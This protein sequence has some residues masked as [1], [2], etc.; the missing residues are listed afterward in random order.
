MTLMNENQ[1]PKEA[2][3]SMFAILLL[4]FERMMLMM[5][6]ILRKGSQRARLQVFSS[7]SKLTF[8]PSYRSIGFLIPLSVALDATPHV[9]DQLNTCDKDT[10]ES[11]PNA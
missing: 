2:R 10:N 3:E 4:Q 11:A 5:V 6:V 7:N 1:T 8:P 9:A